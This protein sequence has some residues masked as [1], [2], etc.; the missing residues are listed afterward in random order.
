MMY[1]CGSRGEPIVE[2][3]DTHRVC[4]PLPLR[5]S[6]FCTYLLFFF[7]IQFNDF[8][9]QENN[10]KKN[11]IQLSLQIFFYPHVSHVSHFFIHNE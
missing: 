2:L 4:A 8:F 5:V 6:E 9:I 11:C 7:S 10:D 1:A 3:I